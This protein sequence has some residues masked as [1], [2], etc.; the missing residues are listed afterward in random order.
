LRRETAIVIQARVLFALVMREMSTR[1]G[2]SSGGYVWAVLDPVVA[3]LIMTAIFSQISRHP[4]LGRDFALFFATGYMAFHIYKDISDYV[5]NAISSN[6]ALL[7]FPRIS[8]VDT[9][10]AR[11]ILQF[12]TSVFVTFLLLSYLYLVSTDQYIIRVEY[13]F[14]AIGLAAVL[15]LGVGALNCLLFPYSATWQKVFSLL[16][17]PL[18]IISGVFFLVEELPAWARDALWWNPLTH[19]VAT[20][21][22]GFY[23]M[24]HP[25]FVS[26]VYVI[27]VGVGILIFA[28]LLLRR[29]QGAILER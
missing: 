14:G 29:L 20:M 26:P 25:D 12:I 1:F 9:I 22:V 15:G 11:F 10:L 19:V 8:I 18:F 6:K 7:N 13:I 21:R 24:Y 28:V 16:N 5:S 3:V 27:A 4:P 23:P 17:R 2:R